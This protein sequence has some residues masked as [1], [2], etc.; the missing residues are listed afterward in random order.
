MA[1]LVAAAPLA[2]AGPAVG[3]TGGLLLACFALVVLIGIQR[4]YD[5]T[6]GAFLRGLADRVDDIWVVGGPLANALEAL[7]TFVMRQIGHGITALEQAVAV[8]WDGLA[9]VIRETGDAI[10]AFGADV[11][12]AI[13]GLVYGE[14]PQQIEARTGRL[15]R[16]VA[17]T[18]SGLDARL[19]AEA[20]ARSRGIDVLNR[21]LTAEARARERGIDRVN[22]RI[23]TVVLPRVR[24]VEQGLADVVGFT[25]RNLARRLTRVEE[26]LAV[27][28]LGAVAI[29]AVTRVFPYWQCSNV[30]RF[31]R[32][33][34]RAPAGLL[35]DLLGL[36]LAFVA[37]VSIVSFARELQALTDGASSAVHAFV[38]ED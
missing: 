34:C 15:R 8:L 5:Y 22:E 20:R 28:A 4:G 37:S 11:H 23:T 32:A 30:R 33:L 7:D 3:I 29:A 38:V 18:R 12:D 10:V 13:A 6:F 2:P 19:D 27:G 26:R 24:A 25:R 36:A 1:E 31:N 21:D 16:D 9:Y 35:D 14:I 17:T